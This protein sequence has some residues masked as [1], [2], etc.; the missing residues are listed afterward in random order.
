M[1]RDEYLANADVRRFVKWAGRLVRGEMGLEHSWKDKRGGLPFCCSSL[2]EAFQSYRWPNTVN[3]D[4]FMDTVRKFDGFRHTFDQIGVVS[5]DDDHARF[6][7]NA[8]EILE[9]GKIPKRKNLLDGWRRWKPAQLETYISDIK[10]N[11]EPAYADTSKLGWINYMGS[12]FSKIY[13][14]LIP[15]LPIYDSR[16]A[17]AFA[18]LVDHHCRNIGLS[19]APSQLALGVPGGQGNPNG[20]CKPSIRYDQKS[21]YAKANLQFAWLMQALVA[22]PGDFAAVA[23]AQRVDALQSA[24]FMLGYARLADDAI[25]K[26]R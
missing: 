7:A 17:C 18:C 13:S 21:K 25:V 2:Y 22:D 12:G 3:G 16:V 5:T 1:N 24:L 8:Q 15:G 11:L 14:A 9:W 4:T 23:K 10:C 6:I 20:R 26:S 19:S